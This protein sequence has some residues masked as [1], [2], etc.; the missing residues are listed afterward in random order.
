MDSQPFPRKEVSCCE[1]Y[2]G[3][4]VGLSGDMSAEHAY[5]MQQSRDFS[6]LILKLS[7]KIEAVVAY[8]S[9]TIAQSSITLWLSPR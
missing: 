1:R 3:V 4:R 5:R 9:Y 2:L 6:E 7:S 8:L